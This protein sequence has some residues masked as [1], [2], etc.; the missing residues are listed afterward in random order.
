MHIPSS[1]LASLLSAACQL[2]LLDKSTMSRAQFHDYFD[3]NLDGST[4]GM[5]DFGL[6]RL[7]GH[8]LRSQHQGRWRGGGCGHLKGQ[9]H[10]GVTLSRPCW[11]ALLTT[12]YRAACTVHLTGPLGCRLPHDQVLH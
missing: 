10:P 2:D 1:L 8:A 11:F 12:M 5:W 4:T 9:S 6:S 3:Y 7:I